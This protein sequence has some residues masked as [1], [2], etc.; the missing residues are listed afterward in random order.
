MGE[1]GGAFVACIRSD[2]EV[3]LRSL[4]VRR[5]EGQDLVEFAMI[6]P[7]LL[8]LVLGIIELGFI[9]FAY[10]TIANAAREGARTGIVPDATE[11]DVRD[12][13]LQR[14]LALNVTADDVTVTLGSTVQVEVTYE[15]SLLI[16]F[17]MQALGLQPTVELHAVST[18][19]AE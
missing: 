11:S 7:V 2:R 1:V 4:K 5:D 12:A 6:L 15:H 17:I 18:M 10:D 3:V 16:G 14:A 8:L 19:R 9:V 13:V